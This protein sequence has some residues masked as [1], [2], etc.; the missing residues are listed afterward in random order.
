MPVTGL[1]ATVEHR[2]D[3]VK[4]RTEPVNRLYVEL[5]YLSRR[6]TPQPERPSCLR[7]AAAGP[8][9]RCRRKT[10]RGPSRGSDC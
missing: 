4:T 6:R 8:F 3:L 1:R 2:D 9:P 7:D 5:T 10:L